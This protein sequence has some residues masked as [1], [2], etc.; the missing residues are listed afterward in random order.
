M[1]MLGKHLT[2]VIG[3]HNNSASHRHCC[4][5]W[6]DLENKLKRGKQLIQKFRKIFKGKLV[7]GATSLQLLWML[8]FSEIKIIW[9]YGEHQMG[10]Q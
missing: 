5:K 3:I 10:A 6:K 9:I 8:L 2:S 7:S 1:K 4:M